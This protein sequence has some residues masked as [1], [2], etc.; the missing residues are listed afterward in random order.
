MLSISPFILDVPHFKVL[1]SDVIALSRSR[2]LSFERREVVR[3]LSSLLKFDGDIIVSHHPNG[4]PFILNFPNLNLSV[5]HC[6]SAIAVLLSLNFSFVGIDVEDISDRSISVKHKFMTSK[7]L[8]LFSNVSSNCPIGWKK[9][10]ATALWSAKEAIYKAYSSDF[11]CLKLMDME[12]CS[13]MLDFMT[14]IHRRQCAMS[15]NIHSS[16]H[17]FTTKVELS[18]PGSNIVMAYVVE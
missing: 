13:S 10:I 15:F 1:S 6:K 11:P 5:S 18:L 17:S 3:F 4:A 9:V 7:E 14:F 16:I 2:A 12:C 8:S